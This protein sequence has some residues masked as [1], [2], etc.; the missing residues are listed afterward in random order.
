MQN[1]VNKMDD[2]KQVLKFVKSMVP[3]LGGA[4]PM[5]PKVGDEE[6]K[7]SIQISGD[8]SPLLEGGISFIAGT[9]QAIEQD[10]MKKMLF[11][12]T[13]GQALTHFSDFEQ[14]GQLKSCYLVVF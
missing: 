2:Y 4:R 11:R 13:R 10:R 6:M 8:S 5:N 14:D 9:I 1:D 7:G 12:A 3:Q